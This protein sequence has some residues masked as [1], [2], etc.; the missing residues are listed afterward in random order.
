MILHMKRSCSKKAELLAKIY[1]H[2]TSAYKYGYQLLTMMWSDGNTS[3]PLDSRLI[4]TENAKNRI[5][6]AKSFD[7]RSNAHKIRKEAQSKANS[8]VLEILKRVKKYSIGTNYV[9]FDTWFCFPTSLINIKKL[10]FNVIG[11]IKKTPKQ[12]FVYNHKAM[13]LTEI[14]R[15]NRKRR[16]NSKYLLSVIVQVCS[17]NN[18]IPAKV[19][20]VRDRNNRKKYLC[21]ISTDITL[22]EEEIIQTYGKRWDIEVFFKICKSQLKLTSECRAI[23][24]DA[25]TAHVAIVFSRYMILRMSKDAVQTSAR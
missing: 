18:Y 7:K 14:Y 21:L 20:Y 5:N 8:V 17:G 22:S 25:M 16:G 4:S 11:M 19:V 6:E 2:S 1:D 13:P 15:I 12:H 23:S 3:I 9:L 10:G 24:Y